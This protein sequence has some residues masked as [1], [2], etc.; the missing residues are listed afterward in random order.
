VLPLR[1]VL[2]TNVV[3]SGALKPN[4]LERSA[5]IFALT[6]PAALF[7]THEI[8]AEY[9]EVL[10]RPE[11][12]IPAKERSGLIGLVNARSRLV[13][14]KRKLT[15]C[16]DADDDIFLECAEAGRADYLITGNKRHFP[17]HWRATKIVNAREFLD[18]VAPHL[19]G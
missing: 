13:V 3:V 10:A 16:R 6:P 9:A 2:D 7:V 8:L 4:G 14:P 19:P 17:A 1:L 18:I 5:L 15:V 12:R 11:L